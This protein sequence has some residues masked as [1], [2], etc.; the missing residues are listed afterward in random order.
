MQIMKQYKCT[1]KIF[2]WVVQQIAATWH[3]LQTFY[4][5]NPQHPIYHLLSMV[6]DTTEIIQGK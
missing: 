5:I 3:T 4:I 6:N 1:R 2:Q